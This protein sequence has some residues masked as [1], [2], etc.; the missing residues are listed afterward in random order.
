MRRPAIH[1]FLIEPLKD[2]DARVKPAHDKV[3]KDATP[4][5]PA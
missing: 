4:H 2:V 3:P 1:G 5:Q